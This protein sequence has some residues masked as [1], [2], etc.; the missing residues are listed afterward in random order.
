M[1]EKVDVWSLGHIFF[2]L[3]CLNEPWHKLE[4]GYVKGGEIRK[5][6][7]N[8]QVKRGI[9]PTI[10]KEVMNTSDAEV[11]VIREAMLACYNFVPKQRPSARDIANFLNKGLEE[12]SQHALRRRPGKDHWG[13]F[14]LGKKK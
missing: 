11:L 10:P 7:V 8:E 6:Y 12:L 9:L 2:R 1:S 13:S 4:P 5:D 3:I 14:R